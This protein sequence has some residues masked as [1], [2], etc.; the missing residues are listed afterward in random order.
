MTDE[1]KIYEAYKLAVGARNFHYD[2]FN[3]WMTYF[4]I[5]IGAIFVAEISTTNPRFLT[6]LPILGFSFT[7]LGYLSCKGYYFWIYNWHNQVTRFE[8]I[9]NERKIGEENLKLRVYSVFSE[10]TKND[11]D[12]INGIVQSANISTSKVNLMFFFIICIGWAYFLIRPFIVSS[13]LCILWQ[14]IISILASI[15]LTFV[16]LNIAGC[17]LKSDIKDHH[18]TKP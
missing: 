7:V 8:N 3:K 10:G 2:N 16:I 1:A 14:R 5:A 9:I 18:L 12:S 15:L 11:R 6:I 4:Y 17:F 13:C